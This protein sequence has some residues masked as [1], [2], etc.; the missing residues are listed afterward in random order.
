[1]RAVSLPFDY[2]QRLWSRSAQPLVWESL[3]DLGA[4]YDPS[5]GETHFLAELPALLLPLISDDPMTASALVDRL[6]GPGGLDAQANAR[7]VAAL[8]YLEDAEL[9]ES[10]APPRD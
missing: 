6:A 4:V 5:S 9:V 7:I 2:E 10:G 3:A 8:N 1:M